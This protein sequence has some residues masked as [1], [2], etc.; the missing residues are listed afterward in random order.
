MT[1]RRPS[2]LSTIEQAL[3]GAL[4]LGVVAMLS[5]PAARAAA[6]AVGWLPFWLVALPA[7][8]WFTA[9]A[10]RLREATAA[11]GAGASPRRPPASV[12]AIAGARAARPRTASSLRRAA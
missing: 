5:F 4:A 6:E 3:L 1:P 7:S 12:H 10:L 2:P 11:T 8:A 9:R